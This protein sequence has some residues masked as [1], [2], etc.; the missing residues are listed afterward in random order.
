MNI[1]GGGVVVRRSPHDFPLTLGRL[2]QAVAAHGAA[3][4]AVIDH[5]A[6]AEKAALSMPPTTVVIFGNP[7]VG[8]PLML[9]A[10][11]V[12]LDLPS[13]VLVRQAEDVVEVA[14]TN[15]AALAARHG[16]APAQLTGLSGLVRVVDDALAG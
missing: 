15:P 9:V 1:S 8:T 2:T 10:P 7:A 11:D 6:N 5:T 13:R 14:Y 16:L 4:F 3:V 12:A